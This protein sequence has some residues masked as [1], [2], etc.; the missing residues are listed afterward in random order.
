MRTGK[1]KSLAVG[2]KGNKIF[3]SGNSVNEKNFPEGNWERLI[4]DGHIVEDVV[5]VS[6]IDADAHKIII[7]SGDE[8]LK[9]NGGGSID[10][11][12]EEEDHGSENKILTID[13]ISEEQL[14][15]DLREAEI[16][17]NKKADKETLFDLWLTLKK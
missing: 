12:V 2:G 4:K 16:G 10:E 13:D 17:F 3:R 11:E 8:D 9:N 14:K 5:E 7:P 6:K 1:V 15:K